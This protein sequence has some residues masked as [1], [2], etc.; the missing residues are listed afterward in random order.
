MVLDCIFCKIVKG[1]IPSTKVYESNNFIGILDIN[2]ISEWH[3]LVI[4]K[5]H[6]NTILDLPN[7]LGMELIEAIKTISLKF[8]ENWKMEGF[9]VFQSNYKCAQQEVPHLHFHIVPRKKGDKLNLR[10]K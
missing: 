9:N 7:S 5:K 10:F 2:P 3:T 6:F 1:E 8:I 4:P